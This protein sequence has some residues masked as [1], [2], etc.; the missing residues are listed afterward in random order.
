[1]SEPIFYNLRAAA[2]EA[3]I[4]PQTLYD[5]YLRLHPPVL[6]GGNPMLTSAQVQAIKA[7]VRQRKNGKGKARTVSQ[8]V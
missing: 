7:E 1:M 8:R 2:K 3:G 4:S 5:T 6:V